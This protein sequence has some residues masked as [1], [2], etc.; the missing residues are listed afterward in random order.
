MKKIFNVNYKT[1]MLVPFATFMMGCVKH[2]NVIEDKNDEYKI[3]VIKDIKTNQ[4]RFFDYSSAEQS[5][6][7]TD[8][9]VFR[10]GDTIELRTGLMYND[11][12]LYEQTPFVHSKYFKMKYNEEALRYRAD[13]IRWAKTILQLRKIFRENQQKNK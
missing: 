2:K 4:E 6:K 3:W 5:N 10:P 7:H 11:E 12:Y 8:F 9:E 1:L 13:S